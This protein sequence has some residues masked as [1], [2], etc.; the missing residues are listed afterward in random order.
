MICSGIAS[1]NNVKRVMQLLI[2]KEANFA[3]LYKK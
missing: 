3:N 1:A 2:T